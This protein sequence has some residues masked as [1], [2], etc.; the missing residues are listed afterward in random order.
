MVVVA[1]DDS[2]SDD[3]GSDDS[4]DEDSGAVSGG[5]VSGGAVS[6]GAVSGAAVSGGEV[7]GTVSAGSSPGPVPVPSPT[8]LARRV[9][10]VAAA[11]ATTAA[12]RRRPCRHRR[13]WGDDPGGVAALAPAP[14][15]WRST[16]G[17]TASDVSTGL[18]GVSASVDARNTLSDV[19]S[20]T[21]VPSAEA[22]AAVG[23]G[24]GSGT[25]T[26]GAI[27]GGAVGAVAMVTAT[28]DV[29]MRRSGT[30]VVVDD[31]AARAFGGRSVLSVP[32]DPS[33]VV[34]SKT[35]IAR[36]TT[37]A[38]PATRPM[39]WGSFH[40]RPLGSFSSHASSGDGAL[41]PAGRDPDP[42]LQGSRL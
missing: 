13:L 34:S 4:G 7:S 17:S 22:S 10:V 14:R 32:C 25:A 9:D 12:G 38:A 37:T 30:V 18:G 40:H 24:G 31:D 20:G 28:V 2:G 36:T 6:G 41:S 39:A 26:G 27:S 16:A 19:C 11:V 33:P 29:A 8:A 42:S 35:T 1:S 21:V 15:W 3:S 23:G 5:T